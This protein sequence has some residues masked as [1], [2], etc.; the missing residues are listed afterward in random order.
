MSRRPAGP[1]SDTNMAPNSDLAAAASPRGA[2]RS[3]SASCVACMPARARAPDKRCT[4]R[5]AGR[6]AR[7]QVSRICLP[8]P[9]G[10]GAAP[11]RR[12]DR[13]PQGGAA[14]GTAAP[15]GYRPVARGG[16]GAADGSPLP[17]GS[18]LCGRARGAGSYGAAR[19]GAAGQLAAPAGYACAQTCCRPRNAGKGRGRRADR[20]RGRG[21]G[22]GRRR[23]SF[24]PPCAVLDPYQFVPVG[25]ASAPELGDHIGRRNVRVVVLAQK[26][27][28]GAGLGR[29]YRVEPK[30]LGLRA[31]PLLLP[32]LRHPCI[33]GRG[34]A[35]TGQRGPSRA[36]LP[37]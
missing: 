19:C 12:L 20:R 18:G 13:T 7:I 10:G 11:R 4:D 1:A 21:R 34:A 33:F 22:R 32:P 35:G 6:V 27:A 5:H 25:G 36:G 23:P 15:T 30:R 31:R 29:K 17:Q 37:S 14:R 26:V 16:S 24:P 2:E 8:A 9:G 3:A 28:D